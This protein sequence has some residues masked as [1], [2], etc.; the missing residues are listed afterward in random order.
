MTLARTPA[1]RS[2]LTWLNKNTYAVCGSDRP[3]SR[4]THPQRGGKCPFN[5]PTPSGDAEADEDVRSLVR[6]AS[7]T[8]PTTSPPARDDT[9][10]GSLTRKA[11]SHTPISARPWLVLARLATAQGIEASKSLSRRSRRAGWR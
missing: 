8:P 7:N 4:L 2:A 10:P 11:L 9:A 5:T 6:K 1:E 3:I